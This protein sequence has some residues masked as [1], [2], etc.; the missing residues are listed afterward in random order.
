MARRWKFELTTPMGMVDH[1]IHDDG[2]WEWDPSPPRMGAD[3]NA[4]L[5][6]RMDQAWRQFERLGW[7]KGEFTRL[8]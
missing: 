7:T 2:T 8:P 6:H 1:Y 3:D 4:E 5:L